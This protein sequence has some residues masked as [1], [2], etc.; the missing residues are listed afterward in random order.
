MNNK[1][2][3]DLGEVPPKAK[4]NKERHKWV[5]DA[6]IRYALK[7]DLVDVATIWYSDPDAT[8]HGEGI[9]A[10]MTMESIKNVDEQIGRIIAS[11]SELGMEN[12]VNVIIS[13]DHGFATHKGN[14]GIAAHLIENGLKKAKDSNDIIVVGNAI[15]IAENSKQ[16]SVQ[17]IKSLISEEWVGAIFV[18][19]ELKLDEDL[20]G[21]LFSLETFNWDHAQRA[22]D[23]Y[24]DV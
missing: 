19:S 11:I 12:R 14:P 20:S 2:I 1:V 7:E 10:P 18:N 13:A 3:Q 4:P 23:L 24:V 21:N 22:A 6:F 5:T 9:G 15:Y 17:I 16:N 8:A